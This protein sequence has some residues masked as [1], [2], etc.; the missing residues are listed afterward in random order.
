MCPW[1][2]ALWV[3]I[4]LSAVLLFCAIIESVCLLCCRVE[5]WPLYVTKTLIVFI[6]LRLNISV[7]FL[8]VSTAYLSENS[9]FLN[10]FL[11]GVTLNCRLRNFTVIS[12]LKCVKSV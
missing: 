1:A 4:L 9:L 6:L 10:V 12:Y 8:L 11:G 2:F 7:E 3:F 5:I